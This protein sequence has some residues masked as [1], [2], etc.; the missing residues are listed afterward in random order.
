MQVVASVSNLL[1][2]QKAKW[3]LLTDPLWQIAVVRNSG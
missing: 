2:G 3:L 1:R